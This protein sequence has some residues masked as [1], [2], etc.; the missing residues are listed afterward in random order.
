MNS[1]RTASLLPGEPDTRDP[2][3][4]VSELNARVRARLESGFNQLWVEGELSNLAQ[5]AS[6]HWYFSLKDSRAQV[7]C[8][9]FRQNNMQVQFRPESGQQVRVR[10]RVSLY[11]ARGEYQ[12]IAQHMEPAGEGALRQAFEELKNRLQAEGLFNPEHKQALPWLPRSIGVITSP[13]GAAIRDVLHVLQRRF[14]AIPVVVYPVP[15][16][17]EE[18]PGRIVEAIRLATERNECDVLIL[19]RGG[20]SLEDLWSFN[21]E[22]VARAVHA[23]PLPIVAGVGHEID[24]TIADFVADLRAPTPSA[25]AEAVSP[26]RGEL[27]Q[28]VNGLAQRLQHAGLRIIRD[29]DSR[30]RA[31]TQRMNALHPGRRINEQIQRLDELWLRLDRANRLGLRQRSERLRALSDRLHAHSPARRLQQHQDRLGHQHQRLEGAIHR[32]LDSLARSLAVASRGLTAVSPLATLER[33]YAIARQPDG[34]VITDAGQLRAGDPLNLRLARGELL[35]DVRE[36]RAAS[37]NN[38]DT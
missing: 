10:V 7:R 8:A 6:G 11:E 30:L 33:G 1:P 23:C 34:T 15:V 2:V 16:Q 32:R 4:A 27:A 35:C 21:D 9:M 26:D 12:L 20:G 13:T 14:P 36:S 25:A 29:G 3:L 5:P 28:R 37:E 31:Q 24:F 18:A 22:A 19:T 17:G 38:G